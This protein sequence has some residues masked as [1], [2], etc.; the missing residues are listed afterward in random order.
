[1]MENSLKNMALTLFIITLIAATSA[2]MAYRVTKEPIAL[3]KAAKTTSA[4]AQVLPAFDND[5]AA[6]KQMLDMDGFMVTVYP[7]KR[8]EET[9]GYAVKT[10]T[11][12]GFSGEIHLLVGFLPDGKIHNIQVLQHTETPGLGSKITEPNN[13]LVVMFRGNSPDDLQMSVRKDGGDIDAITAS[14]ISSRAYIDA[15][16]RGYEAMKKYKKV[17]SHE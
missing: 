1:M 13:V 17:E 16:A 14:T 5:H 10:A 11:R 3:A 6:E 9:V 2:G 8:G 15:V 7:A 4:L 12:K